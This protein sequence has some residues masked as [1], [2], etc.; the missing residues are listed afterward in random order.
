MTVTQ[1]CTHGRTLCEATQ[2]GYVYSVYVDEADTWLERE[3]KPD[4]G[5][6]HIFNRLDVDK[7]HQLR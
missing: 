1:P 2:H 4:G 3:Y 6:P 7:D 5:L